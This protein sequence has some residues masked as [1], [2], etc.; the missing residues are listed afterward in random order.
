LHL[1]L[2]QYDDDLEEHDA[3]RSEIIS[4]LGPKGRMA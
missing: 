2:R 4:L 3:A 1:P